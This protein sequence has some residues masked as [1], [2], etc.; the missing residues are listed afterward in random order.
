VCDL[1]F[2]AKPWEWKVLS[3]VLEQTG[4]KLNGKPVN[5]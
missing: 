3:D 1:H 2:S 5:V 4:W